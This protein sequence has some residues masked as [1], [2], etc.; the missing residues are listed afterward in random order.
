MDNT[1]CVFCKIIAGEIPAHKVY[2]DDNFVAFLDINPRAPG[3]VQVIPKT[4]HR[5]VWDV[6]N[7]GEYFEIART[8]AK[9]EQKAFGV[10]MVL[11]RITGEDVPHAHIWIYPDPEK[12]H[13]DKKDFEGNLAKIRAELTT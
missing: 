7:V 5:W 1:N 12:A 9:A 3:H 4:H 2:E 10:E 13:G 8:I 11:S 6:P